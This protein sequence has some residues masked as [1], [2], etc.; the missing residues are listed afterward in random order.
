MQCNRKCYDEYLRI[1]NCFITSMYFEIK[2]KNYSLLS[3]SSYLMC[4]LPIALVTGSFL[5][6]LIISL[7][8]LFFLYI[9]I[10][11]KEWQYYKNFFFIYL[12][13]FHFSYLLDLCLPLILFY[14][15]K[16]L[17]FIFALSSFH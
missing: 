5:S 8:A 9:S 16:V 3:I 15:L 17:Y 12:Y 11:N 2:L 10:K 1:K 14:H 7:I 13:F 6:D 4:L